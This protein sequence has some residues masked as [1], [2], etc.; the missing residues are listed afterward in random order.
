MIT[1]TY[2]V[3]GFPE[4][5]IHFDPAHGTFGLEADKMLII[6]FICAL[7]FGSSGLVYELGFPLK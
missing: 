1:N 7:L 6:S 5:I 2:L 4:H 3:V